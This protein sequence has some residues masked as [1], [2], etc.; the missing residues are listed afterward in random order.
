MTRIE[1]TRRI[2]AP[3]DRIFALISDPHGHVAIDGSGMLLAAPDARPIGAVGDTF[4]MNMDREPLGDLPMGK[5]TVKNTVVRFTPGVEV[6]WQPGAVDRSPIGHTYGYRLAALDG[7]AT[8]VTSYCDW[9]GAH[10]KLL[11]ALTWPIVP[12]SALEKSLEN[13]RRLAEDR[14]GA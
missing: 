2:A 10:P 12:L 9:S 1:T 6:A 3:A 8:E 11:A 5:Y 14:S 7:G 4:V 13:L